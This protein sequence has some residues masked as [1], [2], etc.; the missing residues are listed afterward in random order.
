MFLHKSFIWEE[1]CSRD[2]GQSALSHS[3]CK[4][5]KSAISPEQIDEAASFLAF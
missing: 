1:C 3:D 2:V 4:I 5:F